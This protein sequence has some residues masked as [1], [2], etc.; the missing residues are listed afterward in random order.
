MAKKK[1]RVTLTLDAAVVKRVD[2]VAR[3]T[4]QSRSAV[5][6]GLLRDGVDDQELF[7]KAMTD[8]TLRATFGQIFGSRDFLR[9]M[10]NVMG[11]DVSEDQLK[12]FGEAMGKLT[13]SPSPRLGAG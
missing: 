5:V 7:V 2:R 4:K 3:S 6:E 11:Q 13:G 8:P 10:V 12:L 9:Q 1:Q